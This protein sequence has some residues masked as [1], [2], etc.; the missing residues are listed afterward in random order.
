MYYDS[1]VN[2]NYLM[3]SVKHQS[4]ASLPSLLIIIFYFVGSNEPSLE[5]ACVVYWRES[6]FIKVGV[7][8]TDY[9]SP[10]ELAEIHRYNRE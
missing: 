9:K 4:G 5:T 6:V 10:A 3:I 8:P 2:L 7:V 1:S